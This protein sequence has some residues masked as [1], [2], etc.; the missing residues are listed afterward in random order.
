MRQHES[1]VEKAFCAWCDENSILQSKLSDQGRRGFPDRTV[2]LNN[3]HVL[4]IEFKKP[5]GGKVGP[6]QDDW[7]DRVVTRHHAYLLTDNLSAAK[8]FVSQYKRKAVR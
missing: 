3:G 5:G 6:H 4:F 8:L 7:A 2:F 1:M